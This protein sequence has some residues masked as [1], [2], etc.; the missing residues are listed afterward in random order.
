[1][2]SAKK[3]T[4]AKSL[5][6]VPSGSQ[7]DSVLENLH[8]NNFKS[9]KSREVVDIKAT[10]REGVFVFR[11]PSREVVDLRA[12]TTEILERK[13]NRTRQNLTEMRFQKEKFR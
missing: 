4:G 5:S 7:P 9:V 12:H 2:M 1:M 13:N 10:S 6:R 8:L 3:L 11:A